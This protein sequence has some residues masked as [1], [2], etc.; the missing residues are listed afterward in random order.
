M[1]NNHSY[2]DWVESYFVKYPDVPK[3]FIVKEDLLRQGMNFTNAALPNG[4]FRYKTYFL[5]TYDKTLRSEL[6]E[7][8]PFLVPEDLRIRKGPYDLLDT[9]IHVY[10]NTDSPYLVDRVDGR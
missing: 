5:F 4:A 8:D 3:E 9:L 6:G 1:S 7:E 2:T 10:H